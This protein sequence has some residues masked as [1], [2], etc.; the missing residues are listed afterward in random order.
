MNE[1][2]FALG[3]HGNQLAEWLAF[4]GSQQRHGK[5]KGKMWKIN[6]PHTAFFFPKRYWL[7]ERKVAELD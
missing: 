4:N 2:I 5:K 3:C 6:N 1:L 7:F